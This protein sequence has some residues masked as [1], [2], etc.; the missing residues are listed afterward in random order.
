MD[1]QTERLIWEGLLWQPN[2]FLQVDCFLH[3]HLLHVGW[4]N[5]FLLRV[6]YKMACRNRYLGGTED[7]QMTPRGYPNF[8]FNI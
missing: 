7:G 1:R 6:Q 5:F 8:N 4:K 3:V 2:W